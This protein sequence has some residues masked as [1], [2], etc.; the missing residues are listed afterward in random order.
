[1][2]SDLDRLRDW[3]APLDALALECDGMTRVISAL[4]TRDAISHRVCVG[5][6]EIDGVGIIALHWWVELGSGV[7]CDW[8][9]RQWLG[10]S[11]LVPHGVF[12]VKPGVRYAAKDRFVLEV[13]SLVFEVLAGMAPDEYQLAPVGFK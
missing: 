6:L 9:A 12:V 4:L 7:V 2:A 13:E 3:L 10:S 11:H 5:R 8:R 1:M